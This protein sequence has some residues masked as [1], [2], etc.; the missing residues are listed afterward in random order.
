M[1][2]DMHLHPKA[3]VL[4]TVCTTRPAFQTSKFPAQQEASALSQERPLG[5]EEQCI[6]TLFAADNMRKLKES[7]LEAQK[8]KE[9]E[10]SRRSGG[11]RRSSNRWDCVLL[12]TSG[13]DGTDAGAA[14]AGRAT[15]SSSAQDAIL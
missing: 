5:V 13:R 15:R 3:A 12:T 2:E 8:E 6:V 10:W 7:E 9:L 1:P 4:S 11:R 14:L